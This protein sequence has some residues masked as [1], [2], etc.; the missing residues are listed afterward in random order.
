MTAPTIKQ[1]AIDLLW[2]VGAAAVALIV[3]SFA[4]AIAAWF[5]NIETNAVVESVIGVIAAI[6][7][8]YFGLQTVN[9]RKKNGDA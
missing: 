6:G 4:L 3:I 1:K 2:I 9:A 7:G 5:L 8:G